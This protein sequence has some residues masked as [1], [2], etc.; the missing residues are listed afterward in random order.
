MKSNA[1]FEGV[2][3]FNIQPLGKGCRFGIKVSSKKQ[4]NSYTKGSFINC[5]HN[6]PLQ[7]GIYTLE[8][9]FGDNEYNGKNTLELI[10]MRANL[11]QGGQPQGG[12]QAQPQRQAP[13]VQVMPDI[14][15]DEDEVP[16]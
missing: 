12:Y 9:F 15:I 6:Q 5:K 11:E 13:T 2:K 10:V 14:D 1:K 7:E 8:G 3:I 4:D 16:F